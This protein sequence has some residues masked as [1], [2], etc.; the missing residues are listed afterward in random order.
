MTTEVA[1]INRQ[2]I[3]LAADSAVTISLVVGNRLAGGTKIFNT[4]NKL[5]SLS[6]F[7]PIGVMVYGDASLTGVPWESLIK[8]YRAKLGKTYFPTISA[9]AEDFLN[10]LSNNTHY[11]LPEDQE[12]SFRAVILSTFFNIKQNIEKELLGIKKESKDGKVTS[13]RIKTI[14]DEA[15]DDCFNYLDKKKFAAG[16][17]K[18]FATSLISENDAVTN[19]LMDQVFEDLKINKSNKSK[20]HKIAGLSVCKDD[21]SSGYS[22]IVIA[23]FGRDEM[24]PDLKP[25]KIQGV[26]QGKVKYAFDSSKEYSNRPH[27]S[28]IPFAQE[29]VIYTFVAGLSS[30]LLNIQVQSIERIL[31][32]WFD[33]FT[34]AM[35][36]NSPE[37]MP[38]DT[39]ESVK[40]QSKETK[41]ALVHEFVEE[42]RKYQHDNFIEPVMQTVSNLPKEELAEMAEAL[43]SLTSLRRKVSTDEETVGG[44]TDVAVISKGDGFIW[45]KR[46]HYFDPSLNSD[47]FARRSIVEYN[48]GKNPGMEGE[49]L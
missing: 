42:I 10:F 48:E 25:Y 12:R 31:A 8:V 33:S 45:Y 32:A 37:N 13:T 22:G 16:F 30:H 7:E 41:N 24:V 35:L 9:Y 46:K 47:F 3:A 21:F 44:P 23:G 28:I 27:S 1:I 17:D 40:N 49:D 5:F 26:F 6:R 38:E 18:T 29:D 15:I 14:I 2:A 43:V 19:E 11:F 20:L 4:A 34:S 36:A 39:K